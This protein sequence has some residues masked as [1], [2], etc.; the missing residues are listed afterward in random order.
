MVCSK[1]VC[2]AIYFLKSADTFYQVSSTL[3][4]TSISPHKR[5]T[6]K[7]DF[8]SGGTC[9]FLEGMTT[10]NCLPHFFRC[11]LRVESTG[12]IIGRPLEHFDSE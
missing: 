9:C 11:T 8:P 4:G 5:G 2:C 12:A 1:G 7:D 3:L 6:F 10:V